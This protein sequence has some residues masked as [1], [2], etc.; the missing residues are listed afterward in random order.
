[1]QR[2]IAGFA[3]LA[4]AGCGDGGVNIAYD[5]PYCFQEGEDPDALTAS[6]CDANQLLFFRENGAVEIFSFTENGGGFH[7]I[8]TLEDD[9]LTLGSFD[10]FTLINDRGYVRS[11]L[12]EFDNWLI[13]DT[14]PRGAALERL[15]A[16]LLALDQA[17]VELPDDQ[18]AFV[19]VPLCYEEEA[20]TNG[21]LDEYINHCRNEF[22]TFF[23]SLGPIVTVD[24]DPPQ[25]SVPGAGPVD[26][27]Q[28]QIGSHASSWSLH[29]EVGYPD[30]YSDFDWSLSAEGYPQTARRLHR[31]QVTRLGQP[32]NPNRY[33]TA[34][35]YAFYEGAERE[36]VSEF[37]RTTIYPALKRGLLLAERRAELQ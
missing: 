2:L 15:E 13:P 28:W 20:Y 31:Q 5:Q 32:Y 3:L 12:S 21:R 29:G 7:Q 26:G 17:E 34:L 10:P 11:G 1:M 8:A 24:M 9:V 19:D 22:F 37:Y 23:T 27:P 4:A 18:P 14:G 30:V 25:S 36:T 33:E 16:E 35:A 6:A